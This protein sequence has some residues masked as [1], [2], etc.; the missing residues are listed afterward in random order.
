MEYYINKTGKTKL[1]VSLLLSIMAVFMISKPMSTIYV[2]IMF[3]GYILVVDGLIHFSTYFSLEEQNRVFSFELTQSI[4]DVLLGFA[5]V[6]N[7]A[8][9]ALYL[10]IILGIW[11]VLQGIQEVQIALNLRGIR[12][13]SWGVMLFMSLLSIALGITLIIKPFQSTEMVV[14]ICGGMLLFTQLISIYDITYIL[15]QAKSIK[16]KGTK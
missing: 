6:C 7:Y 10:P 12:N 8:S 13:V 16:S 15:T 2:L 3:F 5:V 9:I 4:I 1:V 11:I 14:K